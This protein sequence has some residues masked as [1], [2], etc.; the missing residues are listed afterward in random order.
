M[1]HRV[2][3]RRYA[4]AV[5][6]PEL[7][8]LILANDAEGQTQAK[9][10]TFTNS[11]DYSLTL[12]S[13]G[14]EI[15]KLPARG[16]QMALDISSFT[17]GATNVLIAYPNLDTN[18]GPDCD[19]WTDLGGTPGTKQR[20]AWMWEGA[21]ATY[22]AYCNPNL[23]GQGICAAQLNC[24]GPAMVQDGTFGTHWE[25]TP[26]GGVG[27]DYVYLSTNAGS[28]PHSP[29]NLCPKGR[30]NDC[31]GIAANIFY[32]V[33]IQWA[34]NEKCTFSSKRTLITTQQCTAVDCPKAYHHPT[35]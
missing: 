31:A 12:L 4:G 28:G 18:Q 25:F 5:L 10:G 29:P 33:P 15:G 20:E 23:S 2:M 24:T 26:N 3:Q 1:I 27:S 11:C 35:D 22:A 21:D 19:K 6:L 34:T 14:R 32:N 9:Q 16:G 7:A 30:A 13:S 8:L 17:P